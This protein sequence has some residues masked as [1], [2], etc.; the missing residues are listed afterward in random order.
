MYTFYK[1]RIQFTQLM[2][3]SKAMTSGRYLRLMVLALI[4]MMCTIPI[5]IY[6][7]Y[8]DNK[9]VT[10]EPW[11]SWA[12]V[13]FGFSFVSQIPAVVWRSD[14]AFRTSVELTRWLFPVC[15]LL[16]FALFGLQGEAW[17]HY[18]QAYWRVAKIFGIFPPLT[19]TSL[20]PS[21][22]Y[23]PTLHIKSP[24]IHT[25]RRWQ[26]A[27]KLNPLASS[28]GSLPVYICS[29][30]TESKLRTPSII[31]SSSFGG[32]DACCDVEKSGGLPSPISTTCPTFPTSCFEAHNGTHPSS[33]RHTSP[34]TA[35]QS[36][37]SHVQQVSASSVV[38]VVSPKDEPKSSATYQRP[39][40]GPGVVTLTSPT[41]FF[42]LPYRT[43]RRVISGPL[44]V[45][46]HTTE[47]RQS[48]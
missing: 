27:P 26:F 28:V 23:V 45:M 7:I 44:R 15:A 41:P 21:S 24:H 30:D 39:F 10:L 16:F 2:S 1:R 3:S 36:A 33:E 43:P 46:V 5:G 35:C 48:D 25:L 42:S 8:I 29:R 32:T 31:S 19:K 47:L 18:V 17:R 11:T 22:R 13:H 4:E 38:P 40:A 12:N 20:P 9:G 37:F 14:P 34:S 6:S